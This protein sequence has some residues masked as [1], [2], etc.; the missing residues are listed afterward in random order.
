MEDTSEVGE[1]ISIFNER[2]GYP[3]SPLSQTVFDLS[4]S[5]STAG[6]NGTN[7]QSSRASSTPTAYY[8][9]TIGSMS[10]IPSSME[11]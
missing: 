7:S 1:L 5:A 9:A 3:S 2:K 4:S 8:T 11:E 6:A 10:S